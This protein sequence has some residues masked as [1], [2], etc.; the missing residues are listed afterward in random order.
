WGTPHGARRSWVPFRVLALGSSRQ[1]PD[2][3]LMSVLLG[4]YCHCCSAEP[5]QVVTSIRAPLVALPPA[6]SR[7]FPDRWTVPS[8]WKF[9]ASFVA[10]VQ[11]EITA[12][13][14][15]LAKPRAASTHLPGMPTT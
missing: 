8:P 15:L 5:V 11:S 6:M 7:Q 3:G 9:H 14:A 10:P 13:L 4:K 1:S 12:G 2:P